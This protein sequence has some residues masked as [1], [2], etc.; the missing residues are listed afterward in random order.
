MCILT[1]LIV[2]CALAS[3]KKHE[4]NLEALQ[5]QIADS[6]VFEDPPLVQLSVVKLVSVVELDTSLFDSGSAVFYVDNGET[7][8]EYGL[9]RCNDKESAVALAV[10][11]E[12]RRTRQTELYTF[13]SK[14]ASLERIDH[15]VIHRDGVYVVYICADNYAAV[16]SLVE[17]TFQ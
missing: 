13:L 7:A 16:Q 3:C 15:C 8:E 11:L 1:A 6:D 17:T 14:P 10:Q 4:V 2:I 9:F 12:A 5:Q